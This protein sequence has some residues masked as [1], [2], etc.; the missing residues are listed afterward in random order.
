MAGVFLAAG[1]VEPSGSDP[2]VIV[3]PSTLQSSG[4]SR[5]SAASRSTKSRSTIAT[6][7]FT[8]CGVAAGLRVSG[9]VTSLFI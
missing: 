2:I 6:G 8:H 5:R 4:S 3:I 9:F 1:P 7:S